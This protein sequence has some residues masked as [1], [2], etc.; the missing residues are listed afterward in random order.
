MSQRRFGSSNHLR[1]L[2]ASPKMSDPRIVI[3]GVGALS[4]N[5]ADR[6]AYFSAV[7][8]GRSGIK[9][10]TSFDATNLP[11][12][13]AG[14]I[15]DLEPGRW[16]DPKSLKHV[17]RTVPMAIAATDEALADAGIVSSE[18]DLETRRRCAVILG[19]GA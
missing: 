16:I 12:R 19:S 17:S 5:G 11:C 8:A 7:A 4:P 2:L 9:P 1:L 10:I 14:E 3:T 13:I 15:R 18:L 6:E